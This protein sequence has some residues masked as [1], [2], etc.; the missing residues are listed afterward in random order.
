MRLAFRSIA[1]YADAP[2]NNYLLLRFLA[3][4]MVIYGHSYAITH[5]PGQMDLIQ[6]ALRFTYSGSV[7]VDIF[8]VIS[9]FLVTASYL[10]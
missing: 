8:F 4:L 10:N 2:Q 6:R 1:S 3:A 7:G 5:L 9:G